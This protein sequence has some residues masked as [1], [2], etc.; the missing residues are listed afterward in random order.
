MAQQL[1]TSH[2]IGELQAP[3]YVVHV[4]TTPPASCGSPTGFYFIAS[5]DRQKRLFAMLMGRSSLGAAC[6]STRPVSGSPLSDIPS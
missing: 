6:E 3:Q 1:Y 2:T 4:V 5:D